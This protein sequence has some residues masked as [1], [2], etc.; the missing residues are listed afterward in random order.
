[1]MDNN[2]NF[3]FENNLDNEIPQKETLK[4]TNG[5]NDVALET[6]CEEVASDNEETTF[7]IERAEEEDEEFVLFYELNKY[8][9]DFPIKYT[10]T[11]LLRQMFKRFCCNLNMTECDSI[12]VAG[13][14]GCGKTS[15]IYYYTEKV[16]DGSIHDC[17]VL[18]ISCE[19]FPCT[20]ESICKALVR[21]V[22]CFVEQGITNLVLFFDDFQNFPGY[23]W[24]DYARIIKKVIYAFGEQ[25]HIK[26]V[27]GIEPDYLTC[28]EEISKNII[29]ASIYY[30]ISQEEYPEKIIQVLQ[31]RICEKMEEHGIDA[32]E[33][34]VF[35]MV[36]SMESASINQS[37]LSY[38]VYLTYLD[39]MMANFSYDGENMISFN[40]IK[41]YYLDRERKEELFSKFTKS[42]KDIARHEA[43]HTLL[44][45][46]SE[47]FLY[48]NSVTVIGLANMGYS[49]L[50]S[51]FGNPSTGWQTKK[52]YIKYIAF[53]LAGRYA[54]GNMDAGA[55][56][57][58]EKA[59][60]I[61]RRFILTTGLFDELGR[62]FYCD[63]DEY[64]K[65]SPKK[66]EIIDELTQKII[67]KAR[68]YCKKKLK[69][70]KPFVKALT[71][72]LYKEMFLSRSEV[73]KLW[74]EYNK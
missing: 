25:I 74:A 67:K 63:A 10:E 23:L 54:E 42:R 35:F 45:L 22:G 15:L 24:S 11:P 9:K 40:G 14:E 43:G 17:T 61:I 20:S 28:N 34:N 36:Y 65:L 13:D 4:E 44:A 6:I 62:E 41:D 51:I 26:F 8:L 48:F 31:P 58:I 52:N 46:L 69:Q 59:N 30:N 3:A 64:D 19:N 21:T 55:Q 49:G 32:I 12:I 7:D 47:D 60:R 1:M 66:K 33:S 71:K 5:E 37:V 56:S 70:Y 38:E 27:I 72:T 53:Y 39:K 18:E 29:N 2:C 57:D 50:T 16:I 68:R 73:L